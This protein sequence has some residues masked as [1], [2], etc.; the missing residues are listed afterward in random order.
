MTK[1]LTLFFIFFTVLLAKAEHYTAGSGAWAA[2]GVWHANDIP[3][4]TIPNN[5]TRNKIRIVANHEVSL[6]SKLTVNKNGGFTLEIFGQLT[7]DALDAKNNLIIIVHPTGKLFITHDMT[8]DNQLDITVHTGGFFTV[9]G[10]IV[11]H[12]NASIA[13]DGYLQANALIGHNTQ[14]NNL[15]GNGT[16]VLN[17]V[18][19]INFEG[20]GGT[21]IVDGITLPIELL[22]FQATT[23]SDRVQL[24]WSTASEINNM[25]F[26]IERLYNGLWVPIG[27]INGHYNHNGILNYSFIDYA[28]NS[29]TNYYRLKQIDYDGAFEYFGPVAANVGSNLYELKIQTIREGNQV[30]VYLPFDGTGLLEVFDLHGRLLNSESIAYSTILSLPRGIFILRF[31]IWGETYTHKT[32]H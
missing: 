28:P 14:T 7:L 8:V 12:N 3:P 19:G 2:E 23:L 11:L 17:Q 9:G 15:S 30:R 20:F 31:T 4:T 13:V 10:N 22:S 5:H 26:E 1:A 29:G 21:I 27:F 6:P 32:S 18:S 16:V 24:K 25:G